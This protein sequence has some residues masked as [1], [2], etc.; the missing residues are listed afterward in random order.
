MDV[1]L[2]DGTVIR[3]VPEGTTQAQLAQRL[4]SA[5]MQV[6]AEWGQ[7]AA[8]IT[9]TEKLTRGLR[10]PLDGGAQLLTKMLP[11][12]VVK[13]GDRLNN[14][15]AD[16]TGLV[17]RLPEGGVDQQVRQSNAAYEAK[18][19]A[20]G[21]TGIDGWR[22]T[23]NVVNPANL[24]IASRLPQA[25]SLAGRI[26]MGAFGGGVSALSQPVT[27][28][29]NFAEEKAKQVLTGVAFGGATPALT[30]GAG[31]LISPKASVDP[32]LALLRAEGVR[33]TIGQTLGGFADRAEQKAMSIPFV[34][35]A[36]ASA[37]GRAADDLNRAVAN[38]ALAPIGQK[39]PQNLTGRDAVTH[40]QRT[41]SDA[42][43]S[44]LPRMTVKAD[45]AFNQ[46]IKALADAVKTGSIDPK[47]ASSFRRILDGDVLGKFKGQQALTGQTLKQIES[48]LTQQINR[49]GASTD[50]DQRLMADALKEVQSSL[51]GLAERSNPTLAP[52]LKAINSGYANFKRMQR[53][54]SSVAAEDGVFSAAQ[55]QSAVKALDRSKDKG[56]FSGGTA[57]MQDLGDAARARLGATVPNSGTADRLMQIGTGAAAFGDPVMTGGLLGAGLLGYSAPVQSML[58]G[59]VS[60]RPQQAQAVAGL[61]NQASPMLAPAGGL[62]ALDVLN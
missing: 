57:L 18:R 3:N 41:L 33:P 60:M 8:P 20:A 28:G 35:D 26:G 7:P 58:R 39:L 54:A 55:L 49:F 25:A 22:L 52:Q 5:G 50:A 23:G 17:A 38:R 46:E 9:R 37:R 30:A 40:V 14:W 32:Q 15:L 24:A 13:A 27:Q 2:P 56:R 21:E 59:A 19:A 44:L 1:R 10:D 62:L 34:G 29:D 53:A 61:L 51:R 36:I 48:D 42:Y 31:R 47:A 6:P 43:E 16:K 11:D 12:G 4:Q 45:S